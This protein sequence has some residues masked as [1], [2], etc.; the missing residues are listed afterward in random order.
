MVTQDPFAYIVEGKE[1]ML[2][3]KQKFSQK[4]M[5][6]VGHLSLSVF[7]H[8]LSRRETY[9]APL[10]EGGGRVETSKRIL[11]ARGEYTNIFVPAKTPSTAFGG[12]RQ[13]VKEVQHNHPKF[14]LECS[15][16]DTFWG[17]C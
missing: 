14:Q 15:S 9:F 13:I 2:G 10:P 8:A 4:K 7:G 12:P 5:A 17:G 11:Q 1:E 6:T 3:E 16:Q